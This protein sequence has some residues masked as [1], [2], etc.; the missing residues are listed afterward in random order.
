MDEAL[1]K[2]NIIEEEATSLVIDDR[3]KEGAVP[4][5]SLAAQNHISQYLPCPNDH[6][7]FTPCMG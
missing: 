7:C 4:K 2:L 1:G 6:K 5:R 3:E